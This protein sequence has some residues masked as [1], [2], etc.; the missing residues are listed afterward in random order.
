MR[1]WM[2]VIVVLMALSGAAA[3]GYRP[4]MKYWE[5]QNAP[6]WKTADVA[7]GDIVSVVN[8]TGTIKPVTQVNVGSFVSGP[9]DPEF[10]LR[11]ASGQLMWKK[12]KRSGN[13][14]EDDG[15]DEE[16][17]PKYIAEF[18]EEVKKDDM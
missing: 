5:Q 9:I 15:E 17:E 14:S 2:I 4:A 7:Q 6:K 12:K 8:A 10:Q 13:G 18:N 1:K 11:D 3:A 16:L